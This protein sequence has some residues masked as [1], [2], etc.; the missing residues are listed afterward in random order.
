MMKAN[1]PN[2]R[3]E[4]RGDAVE[5]NGRS[6]AAGVTERA[7]AVGGTKGKWSASTTT[8]FHLEDLVTQGFLPPRSMLLWSPTQKGKA[9]PTPNSLDHVIPTLFLCRGLSLPLHDFCPWAPSLL[10]LSA[11]SHYAQRGTPHGEFYYTMRVLPGNP[12]PLRA[13]VLFL[14]SEAAKGWLWSIIAEEP[15]SN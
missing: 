11:S 9:M 2:P 6:G 4:G 8:S 15:I 5:E 3:C 7:L 13:L 1:T 10:R 12:A 14:R